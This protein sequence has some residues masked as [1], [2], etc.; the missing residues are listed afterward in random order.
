MALAREEIEFI[1][2]NL[3]F[4]DPFEHEVTA[5]LGAATAGNVTDADLRASV[6]GSLEMAL[7]VEPVIRLYHVVF[8]RLPD[9]PGLD[10]HVNLLRSG[11]TLIE[12]A[13]AFVASPEFAARYG[14]AM[15][16]E[17]LIGRLY[18]ETLGRDGSEAEIQAWIKTGDPIPAIILGLAESPEFAARSVDGIAAFLANIAMGTEDFQG[19]LFDDD[20]PVTTGI[21]EDPDQEDPDQEDSGSTGTD[22]TSGGQNNPGDTGTNT[23]QTP[24]NTAPVAGADTYTV[25]EDTVL[26]VDARTGVLANDTDAEAGSLSAALASGPR[27]GSLTLKS[28]GSFTYTPDLDHAGSDSFTYTLTDGAGGT[29][30][31]QVTLAVI[32]QPDV[33]NLTQGGRGDIFEPVLAGTGTRVVFSSNS[34]FPASDPDDKAETNH[35][36]LF[37]APSRTL[38][39]ITEGADS[40]S[41]NPALS[42]DG[43]RVVFTSKA[44]NLVPDQKDTNGAE[45]IFLYD[46]GKQTLTNLTWDADSYSLRPQISADG[47]RVVFISAATNLVPDQ[48]DTNGTEDIFLYDLSTQSMLNLTPNADNGSFAPRLSADGTR[49]VFMSSATKLVPGQT[50]TNGSAPDLFLYDIKTQTVTNLTLGANGESEGFDLSADGNLVV[51]SSTAT[52]LVPD[53]TDPNGVIQDIFLYDVRSKTIT[54]LTPDGDQ[55]SG[56]PV[57]AAN[58]SRV[59]FTSAASNLLADDDTNER[60]DIFTY[61]IKTA[62]LESLTTGGND[63]SWDARI[64]ADGETVVFTS[65][66]TNLVPETADGNDSLSDVFLYD[67]GQRSLTHITLAAD[68]DSLMPMIAGNGTSLLLASSATNL[69]P[70]RKDPNGHQLDLFLFE[71]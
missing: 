59:V 58:G 41:Y 45:D 26:V 9:P 23:P 43:S 61:D 1:Y 24:T 62:T 42:G 25:K 3:L 13:H 7:Y 55:D 28:D 57:I 31:G 30:T 65:R 16:L 67:F 4:R 60:D 48:T 34:H 39:N 6:S 47:K 64:S 38:T 69:V 68:G 17:T 49:V 54:N 46:A 14:Q 50:D 37:D 19:T 10:L 63:N 51:F 44:A 71:L 27:H 11:L 52:N 40:Y 12:L 21:D 70:G 35:I 56:A 8:A 15:P 36:Y 29:T 53:K 32:G 33:I 22:T 5:W 2:K 66:A 18:Q 20:D